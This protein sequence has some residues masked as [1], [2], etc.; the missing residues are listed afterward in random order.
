MNIQ[1]VLKIPQRLRAVPLGPRYQEIN[2]SI[3]FSV[4]FYQIGM[5]RASPFSL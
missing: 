1:N 2:S 3:N 4:L 5:A